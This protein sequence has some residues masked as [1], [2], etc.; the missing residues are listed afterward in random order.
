MPLILQDG[1]RLG[2]YN[3]R[4]KYS[5]R[6]VAEAEVGRTDLRR[7]IVGKGNWSVLNYLRRK[8]KT[9]RIRDRR[10]SLIFID[11]NTG[12]IFIECTTHEPEDILKLRIEY[13]IFYK[14]DYGLNV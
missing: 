11:I 10:A 14:N 6:L 12:N 5:L 13:L 9:N 1:I 8:Q 2:K 4:Q 7:G 3:P